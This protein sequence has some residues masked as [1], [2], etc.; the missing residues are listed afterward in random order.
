MF[1]ELLS[2]ILAVNF[3]NSLSVHLLQYFFAKRSSNLKCKYKK[4]LHKTFVKKA[5][6]KMLMTLQQGSISP[7][8][9]AQLLH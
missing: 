9:Y 3:T 6:L 4:A 5:A 7:T 1:H 8:F 2:D